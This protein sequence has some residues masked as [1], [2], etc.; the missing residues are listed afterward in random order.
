LIAA[1][2]IARFVRPGLELDRERVVDGALDGAHGLIDLAPA[3][4]TLSSTT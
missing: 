2:S 3:F 4:L 1:L